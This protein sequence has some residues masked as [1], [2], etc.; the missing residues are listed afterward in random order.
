MVG[1]NNFEILNWWLIWYN[2]EWCSDPHLSLYLSW[3]RDISRFISTIRHLAQ[4]YRL[5][6]G[7]RSN[8]PPRPS[9]EPASYTQPVP[10]LS[11]KETAREIGNFYI[12]HG[13]YQNTEKH[14]Q[15]SFLS[16]FPK[17]FSETIFSSFIVF[18]HFLE[19]LEWPLMIVDKYETGCLVEYFQA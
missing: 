16:D 2:M 18:I 4:R 3:Q 17:I 8:L 7:L 5:A 11:M 19:N 13:K 12:K 1:F 6:R 9:R 14:A 15:D 10:A